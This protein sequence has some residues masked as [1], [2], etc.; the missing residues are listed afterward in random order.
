MCCAGWL[1][2]EAGWQDLPCRCRI[3][4]TRLL[5]QVVFFEGGYSEY[6]EDWRRRNGGADPQRIKYR[7]MVL[8]AA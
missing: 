4:C 2:L 5:L 3:P 1:S 8:S 6:A 7:K